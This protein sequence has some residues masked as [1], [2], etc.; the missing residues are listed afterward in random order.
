VQTFIVAD[1]K[2][3]RLHSPHSPM[4]RIARVVVFA[5]V[6]FCASRFG[7]AQNIPLISGGLGFFTNTNGGKTTYYPYIEPV[8]AAPL[9]NHFLVES[10]ATVL[11]TF[12]PKSSGGYQR[13]SVFKTVDYLQAEVF[14]GS[15][16]TVVAGEFLTPFGTYNERLG[17]I[18]VANFQDLPLIYGVGT[19]NT[20]SSVGGQLRGSAVSTENYSISYAAY[21]SSNVN[22]NYFGAE[23]ASGGQGQIYFPKK[24]LEI[25]TSYGRSLAGIHENNVG[26]HLWWEPI[27]SPFR[28]RSEY[29]HAP[30]ADGYWFE[31]DYRLSHFGGTESL[32]GRLEPIFRM[33]Q[34]FRNR[35]D[36]NDGLP[37]F[38]TQE[39]EF[40]L[41]YHLPHEVRINSSYSRQFVSTGDVNIWETG[42]IYRFLFPTWKGKH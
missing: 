21:F 7:I 13:N 30:H 31:T 36:P 26:G 11:D 12:S 14:A 2:R 42:I 8:I 20:G 23:R 10:R 27:N 1:M 19:M 6:A 5:L 32:V 35:P 17:Q 34:T 9:G 16:L 24:G 4:T 28:F 29:A 3:M 37:T 41:N 15:H 22:S 40:G 33:Q 18:W 25:G 38:N 39:P